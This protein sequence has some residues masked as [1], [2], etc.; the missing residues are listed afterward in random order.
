VTDLRQGEHHYYEEEEE[1]EEE[2]QYDPQGQDLTAD[3]L[4]SG[5]NKAVEGKCW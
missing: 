1:E 4:I 5:F 2:E 3:L